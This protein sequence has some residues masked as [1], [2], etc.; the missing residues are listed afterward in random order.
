M[1]DEDLLWLADE[2]LLGFAD[3]VLQ[4]FANEDLQ[5]VAAFLEVD[6][7]LGGMDRARR[8]E[9]RENSKR[10]AHGELSADE[11]EESVASLR[12]TLPMNGLE[13]GRS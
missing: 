10:G 2:D 13:C 4:G 3:E 5:E 6:S 8:K 12:A 11:M 1:K 9:E 7:E